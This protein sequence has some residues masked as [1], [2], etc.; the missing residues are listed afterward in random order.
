MQH[1]RGESIEL[2][3]IHF[4]IYLCRGQTCNV[5]CTEF[6]YSPN[7]L[8]PNSLSRCLRHG[9]LHAGKTRVHLIVRY[10]R[11]NRQPYTHVCTHVKRAST[12]LHRKPRSC[13]SLRLDP[14]IGRVIEREPVFVTSS[15]DTLNAR[16]SW[17]AGSGGEHGASRHRV[18]KVC[19]ESA[20]YYVRSDVA[21]LAK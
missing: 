18:I 10:Q 21:R 20:R 12:V 8:Y 13:R 11:P 1:P 14:S 9:I 6:K 19:K 3:F 17:P 5:R 2:R 7:I 16:R 4:L 15:F